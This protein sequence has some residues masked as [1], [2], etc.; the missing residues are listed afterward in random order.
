MEYLEEPAPGCFF[1]A[2]LGS[3]DERAHL[4]VTREADAIIML[5]KYPYGHGH[6]LIAPHRHVP[7]PADLTD[8]EYQALA[9]A[10]LRAGTVLERAFGPEGMNIGMNLGRAAG[11]GVTDHCHWH[12]LPRW[13]GDTNFMPLLAETKVMSEHLHATL[14]RLRAC[15]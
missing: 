15:L 12:V 10:L 14:D 13:S 8:D 4:V 6:L 2:A 1:C 7:R 9:R 5:N 11:A 3:A